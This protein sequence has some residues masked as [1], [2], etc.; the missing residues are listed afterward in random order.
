ML[1]NITRKKPSDIKLAADV[2]L[3]ILEE[4]AGVIVISDLYLSETIKVCPDTLAY[5]KHLNVSIV[6]RERKSTLKRNKSSKKSTVPA[7]D[8]HISA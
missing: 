4:T 6:A 5:N 2:W 1:L 8:S 7:Q 3:S